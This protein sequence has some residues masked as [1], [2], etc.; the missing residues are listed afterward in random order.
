MKQ[1][2]E[3]IGSLDNST[4]AW[5]EYSVECPRCHN[6]T[7]EYGEVSQT[8]ADGDEHHLCIQCGEEVLALE[9]PEGCTC[10]ENA[11]CDLCSILLVI[12]QEE[13]I[14]G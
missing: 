13:M 10:Q 3:Y 7:E 9:R 11:R 14:R 8:D 5:Y 12:E 2:R 6:Q 4:T 1:H